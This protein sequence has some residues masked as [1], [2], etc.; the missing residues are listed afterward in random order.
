[1]NTARRC[2]WY[3]IFTFPA[4]FMIVFRNARVM[5]TSAEGGDSVHYQLGVAAIRETACT[6]D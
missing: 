1:M 2:R 3:I 5:F 4:V 6:K